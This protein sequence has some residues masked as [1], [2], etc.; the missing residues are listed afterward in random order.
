VHVLLTEK[1]LRSLAWFCRQGQHLEKAAVEGDQV[2]I[3]QSIAGQDVIVQDHAVYRANLIVT[4]VRKPV[5]IGSQCEKKYR[6]RSCK[7]RLVKI[8]PAK[9]DVR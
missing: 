5:S 4:V 3:D 1:R 2:L 9:T 6:D 7:L 8:H